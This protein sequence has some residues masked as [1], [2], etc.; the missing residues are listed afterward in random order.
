M[1]KFFK[2]SLKD[3]REGM[4]ADILAAVARGDKENVIDKGSREDQFST[5]RISDHRRNVHERRLDV[6]RS[7]GMLIAALNKNS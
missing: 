1:Q 5:M 3:I 6:N 2:K 7:R 4:F